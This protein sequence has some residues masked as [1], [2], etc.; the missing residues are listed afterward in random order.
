[1]SNEHGEVIEAVADRRKELAPAVVRLQY[2]RQPGKWERYGQRGWDLSVKDQDHHFSYLIEAISEGDTSVF[3]NYVGWLQQLFEGLKLPDQALEVMLECTRDVL[4]DTFPQEITAVT[5]QYLE[6]GLSH[7]HSAPKTS[8]SFITADNPMHELGRS[9][10]GALLKGERHAA[11]KQIIDAVDQGIAVRDV[12]LHVFQPCQYEVG[13]LWLSNKISVAQEHY[14]SAATQL[15]MSQLYPHIFS[16][17][18]IGRTLVA[19]C[20]GGEL[21]EIGIRTVSDF[22]EMEGWDTYY[23]GANTPTESVVKAVSERE[24]DILGISA[25]MPFHRSALR[26]LISTVRERDDTQGVKILV[27]GYT[28]RESP[29]LWKQVG[30]DGFAPSADQAVTEAMKLVDSGE[31]G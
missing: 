3:T 22:F 13:R 27:G 7:L 16:T 23:M 9:Y 15:I 11:S 6:A 28:L 19:A 5:D 29:E 2:E 24:A 1:M 20:V 26:Q 12:Y 31:I 17:E 21:H 4:R 10:L 14:C 18:R 8:D 30:A 25:T